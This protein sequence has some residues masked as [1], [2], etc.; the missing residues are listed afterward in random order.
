[1]LLSLKMFYDDIRYEYF[2]AQPKNPTEYIKRTN[3]TYPS[4]GD[5]NRTLIHMLLCN[6]NGYE[7]HNGA[8][9]TFDGHFKIISFRRILNKLSL[10]KLINTDYGYKFA[11]NN[12][13]IAAK[14][15]YIKNR[16]KSLERKL[17]AYNN[18]QY[19]PLMS[20]LKPI[21]IHYVYEGRSIF[22]TVPD[23]V[24]DEWF[25]VVMELAQDLKLFINNFEQE[26][27]YTKVEVKEKA[28]RILDRFYSSKAYKDR[29]PEI[30]KRQEKSARLI[31][32]F[33]KEIK[34]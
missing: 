27:P 18:M 19:Y 14:R 10:D 4:G 28:Q 2:G 12:F 13:Y 24:T 30:K 17:T 29:E 1:M 5:A 8:L 15:R 6:G 25:E 20:H 11:F 22:E 31:K 3:Q 7:W 26:Q 16:K 21:D 23:N 9:I 33:L 34:D 32:D